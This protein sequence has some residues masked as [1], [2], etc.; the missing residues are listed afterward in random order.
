MPVSSF[1]C[2]RTPSGISSSQT[3]SSSFA[4]RA[5]AISRLDALGPITRIRISESSARNS[6]PPATVATHKAPAPSSTTAPATSTAPC[7]YAFAFTTAQSCEPSSARSRVRALRRTAPR[8]TVTSLLC[9]VPPALHVAE[10]QLE[11]RV[12]E[13]H[14]PVVFLQL[15]LGQQRS[16]RV[17][18]ARLLHVDGAK[19]PRAVRRLGEEGDRT[20]R[21]LLVRF[22]TAPERV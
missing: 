14:A 12:D 5:S 10:P 19:R 17:V 13:D 22:E 4:S 9:I 11:Q 15:A 7:P 20:Q 2:T 1:R 21:P 8:S 6:R 3:A 16:H 18:R